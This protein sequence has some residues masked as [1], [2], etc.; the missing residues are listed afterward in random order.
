MLDYEGGKHIAPHTYIGATTYV[1]HFFQWGHFAP[2]RCWI[3]KAGNIEP[4]IRI[5][6][7]QPLLH[8]SSSEVVIHTHIRILVQPILYISS[9]EA[10][11][12]TTDV[13]L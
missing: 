7:Q 1:V 3:T 13:G 4:I 9:S 5:Q 8:I 2:Y 11:L 6:L 10:A 12:H